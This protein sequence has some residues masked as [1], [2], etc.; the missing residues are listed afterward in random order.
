MTYR[1]I[2][3]HTGT[4]CDSFS[5]YNGRTVVIEGVSGKVL[6]VRVLETQTTFA[7]RQIHF[8]PSGA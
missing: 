8:Q 6:T 5:F 1:P 2:I 7:L 4:V 3:G